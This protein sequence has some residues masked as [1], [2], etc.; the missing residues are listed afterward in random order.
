MT[1]RRVSVAWVWASV[2]KT[3]WTY[4]DA[5]ENWSEDPVPSGKFYSYQLDLQDCKTETYDLLLLLQ[6][7]G[8]LSIGYFYEGIDQLRIPG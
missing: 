2:M 5:I 4:G 1:S 3:N 6:A 7:F 8:I